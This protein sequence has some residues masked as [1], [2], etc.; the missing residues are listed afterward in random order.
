M[1]TW[2]LMMTGTFAVLTSLT[3]CVAAWFFLLQPPGLVTFDMKATV[4]AF[5]RQSTGLDLTDE[6]RQQLVR[7][8]NQSLFAVTDTYAKQHRVAIL[9]SPAVVTGLPDATREIQA[10]LAIEMNNAARSPETAG[11]IR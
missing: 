6:Q 4:N 1:K 10:R 2:H 9:V 8:F 5:I 11:D 7:R 3:L